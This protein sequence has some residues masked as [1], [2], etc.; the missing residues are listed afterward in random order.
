MGNDE[1]ADNSNTACL[2]ACGEVGLSAK[3]EIE[4]RRRI[5]FRV[6]VEILT[7]HPHHLSSVDI[8]DF[9]ET[10]TKD[11]PHKAIIIIPEAKLIARWTGVAR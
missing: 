6:S 5:V 3:N 7:R 2:D 10:K 9:G 4:R 11:T 1:I 8:Q